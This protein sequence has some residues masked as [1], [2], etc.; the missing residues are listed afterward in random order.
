MGTDS[1]NGSVINIAS[2]G[3]VASSRSVYSTRSDLLFSLLQR[4]AEQ[5]IAL[6]SATDIH[7]IQ[8]PA[9]P[10]APPEKPLA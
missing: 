5:G 10:V 2:F 6:S 7:I 1:I 8:D 9:T 4:C 3:H